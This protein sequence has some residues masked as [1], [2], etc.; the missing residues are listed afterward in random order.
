MQLKISLK[1]IPNARQNEITIEIMEEDRISAKLRISA[2][3]VDGKANK[4][5]IEFLSEYFDVPKSKI[6]LKSG[7]TS[8]N[9]LF[10]IEDSNL[11]R[12]NKNLQ[13]KLC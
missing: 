12:V 1:V 2:P 10:I 6:E 4:A 5:V 11:S 3:P 7:L 9:K 8:K 13:L